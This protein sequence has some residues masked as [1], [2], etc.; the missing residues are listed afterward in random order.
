MKG[1]RNK[2]YIGAWDAS[3]APHCH[4]VVWWTHLGLEMGH[5]SSPVVICPGDDMA[6]QWSWWLLSVGCCV[7]VVNSKKNRW[8][9]EVISFDK[10][11]SVNGSLVSSVSSTSRAKMNI[12]QIGQVIQSLKWTCD[13][14]DFWFFSSTAMS[15]C[16][17]GTERR[18]GGRGWWG[19]W[20]QSS[21]FSQISHKLCIT[22]LYIAH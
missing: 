1:V 16:M 13:I 22:A 11:K 14:L 8:G 4:V 2:T 5:I 9:L 20:Q 18:W 17:Q 19:W 10:K 12:W 15:P 3:Q 21:P 7:I 6:V